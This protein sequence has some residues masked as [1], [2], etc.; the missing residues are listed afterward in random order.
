MKRKIFEVY[1][2][3]RSRQKSSFL[4]SGTDVHN[5]I[6][7][8]PLVDWLKLTRVQNGQQNKPSPFF[9][10][11]I[12]RGCDFEARLVQHMRDRQVPIV[13]VS[14]QITEQTCQDVVQLMKAGIPIIHSAPFRDEEKGIKG[15]IDF[16]VRSDFL[17]VFTGENPLAENLRKLPAPNLTGSYHYVVVDVKFSTLPLRADGIHL[18]NSGNYPA[19][20]SQLWIYTEGIGSI[21]GYRSDFAYIL[22]R[23]YRYTDKGVVISS[24]NCLDKLG[25]IDY[26][27]VDREYIQRT[28]KA[29]EWLKDL[30]ENGRSWTIN[31]PSRPELYPNMCINSGFWNKEK[32]EIAEQ[33]GDITQIWYCGVKNREEALKRGISSWRDPRC[34]SAAIGINGSRGEIIDRIININRQE[35]E[36]ILP[37]VVSTNLHDWKIPGN[38][39][40]VDFETFTDVLSPMEELPQQGKT[41]KIFMIGVWYRD[42]QEWKYKNFVATQATNEEEYRIMNEFVQFV[43]SRANPKLWYW[44]AEQ[45]LWERTENKQ[46]ETA[47]KQENEEKTDNIVDNWQ[48]M[49]NWADLCQ[50]FREEPIVIKG[51]FKFGLKEIAGAMFKNGLI[52]TKLESSCN[53]GMDA[54][55][56]AWQTYQESSDPVRDPR[57][58]D[59]AKYNEFDVKVLWDI[60]G[61]LRKNHSG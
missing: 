17:H 46:M 10:F 28:A 47:L 45:S 22:G 39:M 53:S 16:L 9:D 29:I 30:Q 36:K 1:K 44:H 27:K 43:K 60:L 13:T 48:I 20:K 23:R 35:S 24:L 54:A 59:I 42:D 40:F 57:I 52:D 37:K 51:C 19:Y 41:D 58:L 7:K 6:L 3:T 61:Y 32:Q 5:Y 56:I 12:Q 11:I 4:V 38:E 8:D 26:S 14:N 25:V 34:N 50:I 2:G 49:N 15:I 31:P 18:L 33:I 55:I 21:Q